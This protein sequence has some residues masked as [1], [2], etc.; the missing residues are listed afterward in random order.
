MD[1]TK[2]V[3]FDLRIPK[4]FSL[5][6]SNFSKI[7]Y[8]IYK[9]AVF[10][11][12]RKRKGNLASRPLDFYFF[13]PW[14]PGRGL[15]QGRQWRP[16]SGTYGGRRR[17]GIGGGA[18]GE[19]EGPRC[20]LGWARDGRSERLRGEQGDGGH[21]CRGGSSPVAWGGG[22]RAQELLWGEMVPFPGSI[23]AGEGRR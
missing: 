23:G 19:R 13:S 15:K 6:F 9:F 11:N 5:H 3:Y 18:R 21:G 8:G 14:V 2:V 7:L 1:V 17:G 10:E 20:G 12:K 22:E 16:D 4:H